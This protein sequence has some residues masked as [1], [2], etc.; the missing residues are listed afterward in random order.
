MLIF[1]LNFQPLNKTLTNKQINK[2]AIPAIIAGISEPILS[3][4]DAAI[5]G[6]INLN[7]TESL[8]AIGIVSSFLSMLIWVL[9]QSRSAISTIISQYLGA[10]KVEEVK[11]LPAQAIVIIVIL[12]IIICVTTIPFSESIFKLYNAKG[13]LLEYSAEYYRIRIIGFPFTLYTFALFGV[14][15]GLQN[16][17]YP[18][19]IATIGACI[20][21][22]LDFLFVYGFYE[23]IAPMNLKGAAVASVLS[24]VIMAI[25]TTILI[26]KN[27]PIS[28]TLTT[29]INKE[30][31]KFLT[32]IGNLIIRTLALNL[33][34]FF[35]TSFATAYG[36]NYIAAY[37]IAIN[38]WF[39]TAF[40]VDGYASAGN[41]LSGKLLG[42]K[43]F[44][45]LIELSKRLTKKALIVGILIGAIGGV[46]YKSLGKMFTTDVEVLSIFYAVFWIVLVMQPICA[47]TFVFDGI[48]KGLGKMRD[49]RNVLLLSTFSVF[50]PALFLANY[51]DFKL[52]GVLWAFT[53][54]MIA[55]GLPLIVKFRKQFLPQPRKH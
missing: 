43:Q 18:M 28:L 10:K 25:M 3:I 47:I 50:I 42:A 53:L 8:A 21:I 1:E 2:L 7:A 9:G 4:T 5:V 48:F 17:Y 6:H 22:I 26:L 11:N 14:F 46:F 35:A 31:P 54:W 37:T 55:R 49:L 13:L 15:R 24:Q 34:L 45:T 12:S 30:L 52:H 27:T 16:T 39:L 20:N 36:T 33:A 41:I 44:S 40:A 23:I 51:L 29:P 32:M 38:L 19:I